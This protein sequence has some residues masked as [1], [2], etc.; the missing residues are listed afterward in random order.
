MLSEFFQSTGPALG[1]F[2]VGAAVSAAII[3]VL[4]MFD[5]KPESDTTENQVGEPL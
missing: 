2:V 4:R 3:L 5:R 1:G